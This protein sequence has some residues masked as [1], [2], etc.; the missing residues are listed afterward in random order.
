ME[1]QLTALEFLERMAHR[2][3]PDSRHH[4]IPGVD[5][6]VLHCDPDTGAVSLGPDA[7]G[8]HHPMGN[9]A[10]SQ[11][12]WMLNL[13]ASVMRR[14]PVSETVGI[15]NHRLSLAS[16]PPLIYAMQDGRIAYWIRGGNHPAT[17][18]SLLRHASAAMGVGLSDL[19]VYHHSD[20]IDSTRFNVACPER[21]RY[22]NGDL[23]C[24]G[25]SVRNSL[26]WSHVLQ[27]S[28][29]THHL[30]NGDGA[31]AGYLLDQIS[32]RRSLDAQEQWITMSMQK[33]A[34][35]DD[36]RLQNME[37]L[38]STSI[39]KQSIA[40][41]IATLFADFRAPVDARSA[42]YKMALKRDIGNMYD[43]YRMLAHL[44]SDLNDHP[45]L[46]DRVR[47]NIIGAAGDLVTHPGRCPCCYRRNV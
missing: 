21:A 31:I 40:Q 29:Y 18:A 12:A 4:V 36:Q 46:T 8:Q 35:M 16:S 24:M 34:G 43:I 25:I 2:D 42:L 47:Y 13:P 45:W 37:Q 22:V 32:R 41:A 9:E 44:G 30:D 28:S 27:I 11:V 15:V 26:S 1:K 10:Y 39:G 20:T 6:I 17:T 7:A 5:A 14:A 23:V 3:F 38:A 19:M 33:I